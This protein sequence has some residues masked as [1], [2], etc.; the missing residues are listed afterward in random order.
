MGIFVSRQVHLR[1]STNIVP[2]NQRIRGQQIQLTDGAGAGA[3]GQITDGNIN[4]TNTGTDGNC[5]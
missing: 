1:L 2:T 5:N 3:D 4:A